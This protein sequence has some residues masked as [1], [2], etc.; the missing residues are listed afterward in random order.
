VSECVGYCIGFLQFLL[1]R[2][3]AVLGWELPVT[4]TAG[5]GHVSKQ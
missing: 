5:I 4:V 3:F 2:L 1:P